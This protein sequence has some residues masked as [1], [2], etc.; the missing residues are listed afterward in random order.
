MCPNID[1]DE[2]ITAI[3]LSFELNTIEYDTSKTP[4]PQLI[5]ALRLMIT[6]NV[7]RFGDT[8]C[9]ERNGTAIGSVPASDCATIMLAFYEIEIIGPTF[10]QNFR[11]DA[12]FVDDKIGV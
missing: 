8:Y 7:F 2:G 4:V 9:R 3:L 5:K 10:K 12:M 6:C 1:T 11:L